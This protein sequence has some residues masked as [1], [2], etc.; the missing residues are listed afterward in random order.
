MSPSEAVARV[1]EAEVALAEAGPTPFPVPVSGL[2]AVVAGTL[3][4]LSAEDWWVPGLR[5]RVGAALREVPVARLVDGLA[6]APAAR[7]APPSPAPA[8]RALTAV[9]LALAGPGVAAVHLGV[10]SVADGALSEA[11]NLAALTAAPVI[12]VVA[13]QPL[14]DGAPIG[15]Q[16]AV[17]PVD[18]ARA[19]GLAAVAVDGRDADAVHAAVA[20]ARAARAPTLVRADL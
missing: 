17:D 18:L 3:T 6:G 11:L 4:A 16:A 2:E 8:L 1:R 7:V 14:G 10:G 15:P 13:V 12:F 5:E 20:A 19:H 9:G